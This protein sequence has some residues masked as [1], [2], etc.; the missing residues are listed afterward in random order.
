MV[1]EAPLPPPTAYATEPVPPLKGGAAIDVES[2]TFGGGHVDLSLLP[3][4]L[5]H[6]SR[7]IR[8][9]EVILVGFILFNLRLF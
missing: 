9:G 7:H 1:P 5:D 3:L 6:T 8:D 2:E 4:Y